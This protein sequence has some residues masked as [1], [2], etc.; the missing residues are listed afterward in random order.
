MKIE[1]ALRCL[2][3]PPRV[4]GF[5]GVG[6]R[7]KCLGHVRGQ[8]PFAFEPICKPGSLDALPEIDS[9]IA[10]EIDVAELSAWATSPAAMIPRA[11]SEIVV[12][13]GI[14]LL[15]Q[16]KYLDRAVKILLVPP[17]GDV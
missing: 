2:G 15:Q 7:L 5:P 9:G 1:L 8:A 11:D 17:A 13:L 6:A 12:M 14:M 4:P 10:A 16:V 3:R